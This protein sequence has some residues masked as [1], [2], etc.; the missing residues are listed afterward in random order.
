[1]LF[2]HRKEKITSFVPDR[3]EFLSLAAY[4]FYKGET[5]KDELKLKALSLPMKPGVYIMM[6]VKGEVIYVGKAK[7]LKN[8]VSQYFQSSSGH[9]EKTRAM[10]S[11]IDHFD[12]IVVKTEFEALVLESSLIKRHQP[13]YNILLKDDKGYPFIRLDSKQNYPRFEMVSRWREDGAKYFGPYGGRQST[14]KVIDS[15]SEAFAL[16]TCTRRFPQEFGRARPCL[17]HHMN[18]CM[19]VCRGDISEE[20]YMASIRQAVAVL[21]GKSGDVQAEIMAEMEG[22]AERLAFEYA[23]LLRDRLKSIQRLGQRQNVVSAHMAEMDVL[24]LYRGQTK[25]AAALL[26]YMDGGLLGCEITFLP[27]GSIGGDGEVISAFIEQYYARRPSRVREVLVPVL[28]EDAPTLEQWLSERMER[29]VSLHAPQR[30]DKKKMMEL[31]V[32]NA[33]EEVLRVTTREEADAYTLTALRDLLGLVVVP[34]RIESIDI[35]H[36]GGDSMV[37]ALAVFEDARPRK[38]DARRFIIKSIDGPDDY[39]SVREVLSRRLKHADDPKF[40]RLPDLLLID[41]GQAHAA[42]ALVVLKD[43]NIDIPVFGMVKDDKHRTRALVTTDG[44][45]VS[46][47]QVPVFALIGRIQEETHR[48]AI[49]FHKQRQTK[50]T[51]TSKLDGIPG[52]GAVRKEALLKA[53]KSVSGIKKADVETLSG[54]VP[55][56]V[57]EAVYQTLRK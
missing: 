3:G 17:Q 46:L 42:A 19:A 55:R 51:V 21:E 30:G 12:F 44:R 39:A 31:A 47:G 11:Q 10:V 40:G 2:S 34:R 53:F 37:G 49:T 26:H 36:T 22:A 8:R 24:G 6:D 52:L 23:A 48:Q 14:Q 35:S 1:M 45:E 54:V 56:P 33:R 7:M 13:K 27:Q 5:M 4:R 38:R 20:K 18:R 15:L 9:D 29:K 43:M 32:G 28:P 57:A 25:T 16:P 41:G 50:K